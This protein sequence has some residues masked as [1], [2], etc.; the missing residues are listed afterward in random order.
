MIRTHVLIQHYSLALMATAGGQALQALQKHIS[1]E[2][3]EMVQCLLNTSQRCPSHHG[4]MLLLRIPSP[5]LAAFAHQRLCHVRNRL[6]LHK[7]FE[8]ILGDPCSV[9]TVGKHFL[10]QLRVFTFNLFVFLLKLNYMYSCVHI[11]LYIPKL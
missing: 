6:G 7:Q 9:L 10:D 11:L 3:L 2:T 1:V 5:A 8:V 4:H